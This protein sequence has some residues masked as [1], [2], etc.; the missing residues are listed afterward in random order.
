MRL[1]AKTVSPDFR[2]L[3][4]ASYPGIDRDP[5]YWRM[6]EFLLFG[7]IS[8]ETTGQL[9]ISRA[10][11]A[12]IE[13]R[14]ADLRNHRYKGKAFLDR[15]SRDVTPIDYS[16]WLYTEDRARIVRN[17]VFTQEIRMAL[18]DEL[19]RWDSGKRLYF[20]TGEGFNRRRQA[21]FRASERAAALRDLETADCAKTRQLL[22][23]MNT[24]PSNRF[25]RIVQYIPKAVLAAFEIDHELVRMQQMSLLR[26]IRDEPKPFYKPTGKSVR[27]FPSTE[28]MLMLKREL[29]AIL[30][31]DWM[32]FDLR[33]A[34]LAIC[35]RD[36][37]VEEILIFL[38]QSLNDGPTI[39]DEFAAYLHT[40]CTPPFK[41]AC[42]QALYAL[43]F[44]AG[45]QPVWDAFAH[46][47]QSIEE[48]RRL[49]HHPL[50]RALLDARK[51]QFGQIKQHNG[52]MNCFG[53]WVAV[54]TEWDGGRRRNLPNYRSV[55]AQLAQ[56][57]ELQLLEPVIDLAHQTDQFTITL[58]LHDGFCLDVRDR[59]RADRWAAHII[60]A[61]NEQADKLSIPTELVRTN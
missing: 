28:S 35:A 54:P 23:Y 43:T 21:A 49:L 52:A 59:S 53:Q 8:D 10:T 39:W 20:A 41:A 26:A 51:V 36:W 11:L 60:T 29:R 2:Q 18:H 9:R 19:A 25:M 3:I 38:E 16:D 55:L 4:R 12:Q 6:M 14:Q 37:Q 7:T 50:V 33:S 32:S 15:F 17:P 30:T 47:G 56:A 40:A 57:R 5:A 24:L 13:G 61:V 44:G 48:A 31:Q 46:E 27:I 45:Q 42:K 1:A 58:W 34:Q 22:A